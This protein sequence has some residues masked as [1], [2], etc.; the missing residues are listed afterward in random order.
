MRKLL[1]TLAI[2]AS[3]GSYAQKLPN[4]F[5]AL[6]SYISSEKVETPWMVTIRWLREKGLT[7]K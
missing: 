5:S 6:R 7:M 2:M 4:R 3:V 1:F